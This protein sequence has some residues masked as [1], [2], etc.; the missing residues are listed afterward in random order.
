MKSGQKIVIETERLIIMPLEYP[1]LEKYLKND[2]S[3]EAELKLNKSKRTIPTELV[4]A[5]E[6]DILPSVANQNKNYLFSTL[7]TVISKEQNSIVG[8]LCFM[9]EPNEQ[10]E[11]EIGY[12]TYK[13]FQN[14]GFMTE[15]LNGMINWA[16]NRN[17]IKSIIA[18]T[19]CSNPASQ[20]VLAKNKFI[21][22]ELTNSMITWKYLFQ[23]NKE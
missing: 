8:D 22:Y 6:K 1:Q 13:E 10:S 9:G 5:L 15:A 12:G 19:E 2:N 16:K 21:R 7:W 3:L 14:K 18:Q 11:V 17:E 20:A 4:E 23:G